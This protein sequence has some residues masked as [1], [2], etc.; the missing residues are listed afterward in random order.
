MKPFILEM[1]AS[2]WAIG[3]MLLQKQDDR[4]IHPCG[5]L[6]HALT[7]T[8]Q[9][10]QIYDRELYAII[11]ALDKWKM[12]LV[13][14][15]VR[16]FLVDAEEAVPGVKRWDRVGGVGLGGRGHGRC[17]CCEVVKADC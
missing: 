8:E 5:Y 16:D 7:Q 10:W 9:N 2:K 6:S 13:V 4:Q 11:Y 14:E 12:R 1:D 17:D 3:A 15:E